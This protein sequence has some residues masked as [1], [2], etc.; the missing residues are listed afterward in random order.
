[1]KQETLK[2]LKFIQQDEIEG[3]E[4][5]SRLAKKEKIEKNRKILQKIADSEKGHYAKLKKL[6]KIDRKP[7]MLRVW[8]Y[9]FLASTLGLTFGLKLMENGERQAEEIYEKL[10]KTYPEMEEILRE[11]EEHERELIDMLKEAKLGYM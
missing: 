2:L 8:F 7:R 4:I 9:T 11:E 5:Y 6:T 3:Y 10:K 1:M